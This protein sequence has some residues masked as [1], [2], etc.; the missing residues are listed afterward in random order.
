[1]ALGEFELIRRFFSRHSECDGVVLGVG[2]D[3]AVLEPAAGRELVAVVDTLVG[4]VHFPDALDAVH[5]GFRA[6]AV[7]LSDIAAMGARPRWA[8]LALTL[9]RADAVWLERFAEGLYAALEPSGTALVGGD[10][11]RGEQIVITVQVIGDVPAGRALRRDGAKAGDDIYVS[12]T[13]GD[14]AAGLQQF[15]SGSS[16]TSELVRRFCRPEARLDLGAGLIGLASAA[17][18]VSDGLY[19]DLGKLLSASALGASLD[20]EAIPMSDALAGAFGDDALQLAMAGG[21]DYELCFT[22]S[23]DSAAR[24][25]D[26]AQRLDLA[27]TRIG[28]VDAKTG[29]RCL[30]DGREIS[31]DLRGYDHFR[32]DDD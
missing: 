31:I 13:L 26:C 20:V 7:N 2:D 28:T 21:D 3:G 32:P 1:M 17:I 5:T 15:L 9:D 16:Q 18:D 14:A 25:A 22:A 10:T 19:D 30:Q 4:G 27:L 6:A 12:G 29:I 11:T 23:P 24:I 8:T